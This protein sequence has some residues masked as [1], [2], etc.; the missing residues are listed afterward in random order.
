MCVNDRFYSIQSLEECEH[1]AI[2]YAQGMAAL[3]DGDV[4]VAIQLFEESAKWN[5][6]YRTYERLY[7]CYL[8]VDM[9]KEALE[10]IQ[11]AYM[12]N[13]NNDKTAYNY[14]VL[15]KSHG[16]EEQARA[17]ARDIVARNPHYYAR[18]INKLL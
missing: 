3:E 16:E 18:E 10:A 9:K 2:L 11:N 8:R 4:S 17:I 7:I 6:H 14:A 12:R 15:L 13:P 5:P 1:A